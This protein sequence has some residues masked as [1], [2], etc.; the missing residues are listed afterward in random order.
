[1]PYVF[2]RSVNELFQCVDKAMERA[3]CDPEQ[4]YIMHKAN[5]L[6]FERY[7][8][9]VDNCDVRPGRYCPDKPCI[10]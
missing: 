2:I 3:R 5:S 10:Y 7:A 6:M 1:M 4:A 9:H 8:H